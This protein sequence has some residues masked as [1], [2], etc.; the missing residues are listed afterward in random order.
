MNIMTIVA[1]PDLAVSKANKVFSK[2]QQKAGIYVHDLYDKYP[3]WRVDVQHEQQLLLQHDRVVLQ[4][5]FYWYSCPPLLKKWFD[6]VF[7]FGWAYGPG[8]DK[9]KG[10]SFVIVTTIGGPEDQYASGGSNQ[11]TIREFLRPI[12]R[13]ITRCGARYLPPFATFDVSSLSEEELAQQAKQCLDTIQTPADL[14][15]N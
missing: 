2:E 15:V 13:T 7:S 12:E 10:K 9:L 5:P 3:D 1:H 14:L 8:G 11:Y 6:D 4:F